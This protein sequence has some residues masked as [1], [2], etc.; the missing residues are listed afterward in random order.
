MALHRCIPLDA[1]AEWKEALEGTRYGFA[2]TWEHCY[3]MHLTTGHKT[4]LYYF[5][6]ENVRIVCPIVERS[7][8][9]YVDIVKPFG[10]CGF[11]GNDDYPEF[12]R[13]WKEFARQRGYVCG[14]LGL[15]PVFVND[16]GFSSDEVYQ[17]NNVYVTDL[18]LAQNVL[19]ANLCSERRR[20]LRNYD[21]FLSTHLVDQTAAT[22][23]LLNHYLDFMREKN[24]ESV[25]LLSVETL[26][27]LISSDHVFVVGVQNEGEVVSAATFSY[28]PYIGD[29][30][31]IVSLPQ[32]RQYATALWWYG[33]N[34]LKSLQVRFLNLGGGAAE[35]HDGLTR[36]KRGFGGKELPLKCLKQVYEPEIYTMLCEQ[37]GVDPSDTT[38]YFPL[39]R[40]RR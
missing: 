3:A 10:F 7:F 14:Y 11:I 23:F 5:E 26:S 24:A 37:A 6:H 16:F 12:S 32:G 27:F 4:Y 40:L 36:W 39:Y 25:Y 33:V 35:G 19:Y 28:T 21:Q 20:Q 31:F 13:C 34:Y 17:Y 29:C 30:E 15:D 2:H 1:P 38:G 8:G 9:E 18:S 22:E